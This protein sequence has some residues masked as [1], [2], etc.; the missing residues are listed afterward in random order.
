MLFGPVRQSCTIQNNLFMLWSFQI[1]ISCL[2]F[3]IQQEKPFPWTHISG[4]STAPLHD[5]TINLFF[6][7]FIRT[8]LLFTRSKM[9]LCTSKYIKNAFIILSSTS[10]WFLFPD[11]LL[12]VTNIFKYLHCGTFAQ[13]KKSRVSTDSH[14]CVMAPQ[15]SRFPLQQLDT[16]IMGFPKTQKQQ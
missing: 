1:L 10:T 13:G 6:Y 7:Y 14:C 4:H 16:T 3:I 11:C 9:F 2:T 12:R 15:T 8:K 5:D